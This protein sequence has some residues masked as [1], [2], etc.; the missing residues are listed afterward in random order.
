[1]N[2]DMARTVCKK[3]MISGDLTLILVIF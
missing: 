3:A 1:M 2:T